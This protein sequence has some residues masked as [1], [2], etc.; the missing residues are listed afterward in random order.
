ADVEVGDE[1][2]AAHRAEARHETGAGE[3]FLG[4]RAELLPR[5]LRF[6]QGRFG[7]GLPRGGLPGE[8][9]ARLLERLG[10]DV[11]LDAGGRVRLEVPGLRVE[12]ALRILLDLVEAGLVDGVALH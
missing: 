6:R 12:V 1:L 9:T 8:R 5:R 4:G 2:L 10:G 11:E 7:G 3:L